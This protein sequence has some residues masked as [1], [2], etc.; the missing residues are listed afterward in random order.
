M[1]GE[2]GFARGMW[3]R[4]MVKERRD[5]I[6]C[7]GYW[8]GLFSWGGRSVGYSVYGVC[9]WTVNTYLSDLHFTRV[10]QS[11]SMV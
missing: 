1:E 11:V 5:C 2:V 9:T 7:C 6:I 10:C 8:A 3:K 4:W